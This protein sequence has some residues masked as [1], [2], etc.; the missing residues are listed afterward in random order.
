MLAITQT[1]YYMTLLNYIGLVTGTL[2]GAV[3]F[4]AV[5]YAIVFYARYWR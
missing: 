5:V 4:F 3:A 2:V 1:E